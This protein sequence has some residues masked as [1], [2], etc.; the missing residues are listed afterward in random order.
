MQLEETDDK[1]NV[2]LYI[3][4]FGYELAFY[5]YYG[6]PGEFSP[7]GLIDKIF[8]NVDNTIKTAKDYNVS[9]LIDKIWYVSI[10]IVYILG[11]L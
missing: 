10:I 9:N 7:A 1:I 3:K 5:S 8:D 11:E 2:D 6:N 4:L